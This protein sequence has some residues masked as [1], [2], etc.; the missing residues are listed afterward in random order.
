MKKTVGILSAFLSVCILSSCGGKSDLGSVDVSGKAPGSETEVNIYYWKSGLGIEYMNRLVEEFNQ[1]DNGYTATLTFDNSAANIAKS[2]GNG[3]TN[4]YDLYFTTLNTGIYDSHFILLDDLLDGTIE[5][6]SVTLRD[7]YYDFLLD[8]MKNVDGTTRFLNYGNG[9]CGIVYNTDYV[10]EDEVFNTTQELVNWTLEF[11]LNGYKVNGNIV[12]P[13]IFYNNSETN[14]YWNYVLSAWEAQYDGIDYR[15]DTLMTLTDENGN[16]PSQE[17]LTR[18]DGRYQAIKVLQNLLTSKTTHK[19]CVTTDFTTVQANFMNG[20]AAMTVNG[21]WLLSESAKDEAMKEKAGKLRMMRTPVISSIVETFEGADKNMSDEK[22]SAIVS[23]V[24]EGKTYAECNAGNTACLESTFIRIRDARNYMFNNACQQYVFI[25]V[26]SPAQ[27]AA[28]AFLKLF[29][30]DLGLQIFTDATGL[31]GPCRSSY[32]IS[33]LGEW[34]KTQFAFCESQI[35]VTSP[36]SASSV[37]TKYN[38]NEF[39]NLGVTQPLIASNGAD[40]KTADDL[41][42]QLNALVKLNWDEWSK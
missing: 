40:Y 21:N 7:K 36:K 18:K 39:C 14:G 17:V 32:D 16:S 23:A 29:Y 20:E 11:K 42:A 6:E 5:G 33:S 30:S 19:N 27:E 41:W 15:N 28:K 9:W 35:A 10:G 25:P 38:M 2:L 4:Q 24:D 37:F 34:E 8:G 3:N 31:P 26:Y 1:A 22:L 13:W 12:E